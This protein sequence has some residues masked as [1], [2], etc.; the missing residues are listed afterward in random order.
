[1]G[2]NGAGKSTI[3]KSMVGIQPVTDGE[4]DICGYSISDDPVK[5]KSNIGYVP[6]HYAL[7]EKLSGR[8][9]IN[10]IADI[11][12]V[13]LE[14]RNA[15]IEKYIK[16]FE[17]ESSIDAKIATYSHGMKQKITIMAALVHNFG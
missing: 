10:Y 3:I 1:M 11:Y 14:D 7:Y 16:L 2:P 6:D 13:S 8:E 4:I 12:E 9:Y 5:A 15:R 17:L